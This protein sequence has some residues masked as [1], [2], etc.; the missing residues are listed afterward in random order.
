MLAQEQA[1]APFKRTPIEN[2]GGMLLCQCLV[3]RP[4]K[5]LAI[6]IGKPADGTAKVNN[7]RQRDFVGARLFQKH[8]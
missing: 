8:C 2:S 7:Q 5:V 1:I 3:E 6:A 4:K